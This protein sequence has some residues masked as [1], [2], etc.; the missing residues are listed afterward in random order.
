VFGFL[1]SLSRTSRWNNE[2]AQKQI[3]QIILQGSIKTAES[4]GINT[5]IRE[6]IQVQQTAG[7]SPRETADRCVHAVSM[8][9]LV[10][11]P[12]VYDAAKVEGQVL[13]IAF[14]S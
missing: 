11:S 2:P 12:K 9:R 1:K 13:Y 10:T 4:G 3:V 5:K 8:I 7:W 6:I 14:K